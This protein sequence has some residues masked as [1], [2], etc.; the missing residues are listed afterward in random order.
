MDNLDLL[1]IGSPLAL[2]LIILW[3]VAKAA[4]NSLNQQ[5]ED[6]TKIIT[7]HIHEDVLLHQ[8]TIKTMDRLDKS[9]NQLENT[10]R[11]NTEVNKRLL[12]FLSK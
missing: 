9:L 2:A 7:N 1:K 12:D 3:Q 11:E 8:E 6:F 5:R 10:Q 4:F